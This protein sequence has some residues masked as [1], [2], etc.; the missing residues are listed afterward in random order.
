MIQAFLFYALAMILVGSVGMT[1][2]SR[3]PIRSSLFLL[4]AIFN[5]SG[6][7]VLLGAKVIA[8]TLIFVT[9]FT[10]AVLF[11]CGV[12]MLD[13]NAIQIHRAFKQHFWLASIIGLSFVAEL[14]IFSIVLLVFDVSETAIVLKKTSNIS[15]LS[16]ALYAHY[17]Y[18]AQVFG[19]ILLTSVIG[20]VILTA[21]KTDLNKKD[22][23]QSKPQQF[24]VPVRSARSNEIEPC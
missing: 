17:F 20:F 14:L 19:F 6:L 24:M 11:L 22:Q 21:R 10:I 2:S 4:L 18:I 12:L 7:L 13:I 5:V 16:S 3:D 23:D 15:I 9:S 1:I 8:V